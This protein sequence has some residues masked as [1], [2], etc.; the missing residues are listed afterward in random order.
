MKLIV[1]LTFVSILA[2]AA[3]AQIPAEVPHTIDVI[4]SSVR[5]LADTMMERCDIV[6]GE[7]IAVR[8][9]SH[10]DAAWIQS[11]VLRRLAERGVMASVSETPSGQMLEVVIED[12][13]TR[14]EAT[15]SRD[16]VERAVTVKLSSAC[17][18]RTVMLPSLTHK[19]T[20][21]RQS[22]DVYQSRQH[23]ASH[24]LVPRA[25]SS[26]WDDILEPLIYVAAAA[27]TVVLFFT[28]RTQ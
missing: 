28:V 24:G 12:V 5:D 8:T 13:A 19:S 23:M 11:I 25:Q 6:A 4:E 17:A 3:S 10:P 18:G 2:S 14:Y 21:A 15:P 27:V 7:P 9:S 1:L 16:T 22:V 20:V 26:V